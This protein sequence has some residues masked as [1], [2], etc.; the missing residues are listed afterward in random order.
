[1]GIR[2]WRHFHSG[3]YPVGWS[4]PVP[5]TEMA[6]SHGSGKTKVQNPDLTI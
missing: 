4:W 5:K 3:P 1:M 6:G 2:A